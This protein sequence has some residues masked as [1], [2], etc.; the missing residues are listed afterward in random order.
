MSYADNRHTHMQTD[1]H[2]HRPNTENVIFEFKGP[3]NM[4]IH[5]NLRFENLIQKIYFLY[6]SSLLKVRE[7]KNALKHK[8]IPV[9]HALHKNR[10]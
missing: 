10:K 1:T 5:Q 4:L 2:T 7:S 9:K 6:L 8:N 3:Q